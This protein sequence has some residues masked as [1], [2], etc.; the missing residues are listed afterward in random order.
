MA[1]DEFLSPRKHSRRFL[2]FDLT[3]EEQPGLVEEEN[4][5][6]ET[7]SRGRASEYT[8][9]NKSISSAISKL[10]PEQERIGSRRCID[11]ICS[12][13]DDDLFDNK[14]VQ[15]SIGDETGDEARMELRDNSVPK[16]KI[17]ALLL[18]DAVKLPREL[19]GAPY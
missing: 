7:I 4:S 9:L 5:V 6:L 19:D 13:I 15:N 8:P 10:K 11:R 1:T 12:S 14:L 17:N 2:P 16:D 18:I 3:G